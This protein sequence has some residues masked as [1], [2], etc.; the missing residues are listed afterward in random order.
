[1]VACLFVSCV[2]LT[3]RQ[4]DEYLKQVGRPLAAV[5]AALHDDAALWELAENPLLL[6]IVA[7]AYK[8]T[9]PAKLRASATPAERRRLYLRPPTVDGALRVI[10][11]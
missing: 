8:D 9:S 1:M 10:V 6:S 3:K 7:L 5:R 2:P 11:H 4:V